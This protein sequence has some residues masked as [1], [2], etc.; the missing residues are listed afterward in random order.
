MNQTETDIETAETTTTEIDKDAPLTPE[1]AKLVEDNLGLVGYMLKSVKHLPAFSE[2]LV[3]IGNMALIR[4]AKC[5]DPASGNKFSTYAC[6]GI[7]MDMWAAI[8]KEHKSQMASYSEDV[9]GS[10]E[11]D[12]CGSSVVSEPNDGTDLDNQMI[13]K[14]VLE[15]IGDIPKNYIEALKLSCEGYTLR[16]IGEKLQCSGCAARNW[17][18]KAK[19]MIVKKYGKDFMK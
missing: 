7:R 13:A 11:D 18:E 4:A 6:N 16:E 15:N 19:E 14:D 2:E 9:S 5:Y 8:R 3:S 12:Y 1:Q 10:E 17:R